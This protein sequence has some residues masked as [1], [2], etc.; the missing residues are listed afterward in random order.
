MRGIKVRF[1]TAA[2]LIPQLATAK[3]QGR[4][5]SYLK[6]SVLSPKAVG[7]Q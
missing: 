1:I 7:D 5:D 4:L 2:D 6:R 3:K